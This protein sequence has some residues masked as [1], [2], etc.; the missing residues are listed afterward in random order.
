MDMDMEKEYMTALIRLVKS[1][2]RELGLTI[3]G[4][5]YT[6]YSTQDLKVLADFLERCRDL[7]EMPEYEDE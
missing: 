1:L 6:S 3:P 4:S 7:K 5:I 2:C